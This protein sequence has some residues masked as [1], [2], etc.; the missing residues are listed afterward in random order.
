MRRPDYLLL[1][2]LILGGCASDIT[3]SSS[4][5]GKSRAAEIVVV[6]PDPEE[7][8]AAQLR[9]QEREIQELREA[10]DADRTRTDAATA[11][12]NAASQQAQSAIRELEAELAEVRVRTDAASAQS[13]KAFAIATEFLS[14]LVSARDE[15]RAIVER[16]ISVF[17]RMEARLATIEGRILETRKL[18]QTELAA[19]RTRS[20]DMEQKLKDSDQELLDLRG[21]LLRLHRTNEETRAAIDS[22]PMLDMLRQLEGTQ[23]DTSGLRGALEEMQQEQDVARKRMQNYYL[24]LDARIQDLQDRERA[25]REAEARLLELEGENASAPTASDDIVDMPAAKDEVADESTDE[26]ESAVRETAD[27]TAADKD[28]GIEN[29]TDDESLNDETVEIEASGSDALEQPVQIEPLPLPDEALPEP[30]FD[31]GLTEP[32]SGMLSSPAEPIYDDAV[33]DETIVDEPVDDETIDETVAGESLP[34]TDPGPEEQDG[35]ERVVGDQDA[36]GGSDALPEIVDTIDIVPVEPSLEEA[37]S[38][39]SGEADRLDMEEGSMEETEVAPGDQASP[40]D[41]ESSIKRRRESHAVVITD[42][43]AVTEKR[44]TLG[45]SSAE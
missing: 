39:G 29:A 42:W 14:N 26:K 10:L 45:S 30:T 34:A 11:R 41:L 18:S 8:R 38:P 22:G 7:I 5:P 37:T 35:V 28:A 4:G 32:D 12:S 21:Q 16:N 40:I 1:V 17:D 15:Q 3:T 2:P 20:T 31:A 13:D 33:V 36:G 23:R 43:T 25:A 44:V 6:E 24:D 27:E 9:K 19:T